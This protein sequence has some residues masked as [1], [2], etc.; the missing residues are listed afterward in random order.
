MGTRRA[1]GTA[2]ASASGMSS[3]SISRAKLV[4]TSSS[5]ASF[6]SAD[7]IRPNPPT[8]FMNPNGFK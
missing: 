7:I 6:S 2:C 5:V 3:L 4:T 8:S 1:V